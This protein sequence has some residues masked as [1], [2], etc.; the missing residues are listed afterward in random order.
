MVSKDSE[1]E[2]GCDSPKHSEDE[3]EYNPENKSNQE[4]DIAVKMKMM[5][6]V[7]KIKSRNL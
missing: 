7:E 6:P 5:P 1:S 3:L 4:V 2:A